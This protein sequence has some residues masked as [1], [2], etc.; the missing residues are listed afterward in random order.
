VLIYNWKEHNNKVWN[1]NIKGPKPWRKDK[2]ENFYD[3]IW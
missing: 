2:Q 3:S 1:R